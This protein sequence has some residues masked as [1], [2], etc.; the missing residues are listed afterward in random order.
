MTP[1]GTKLS[2]C[3]ILLYKIAQD[4]AY[5]RSSAS[6]VCQLRIEST[7]CYPQLVESVDVKPW[8]ME[9]EYFKVSVYKGTHPVQTY[10]VQGPTIVR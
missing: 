1:A 5:R 7:D 9:A 3:S 8:D 10:V 6:A 4:N 2:G